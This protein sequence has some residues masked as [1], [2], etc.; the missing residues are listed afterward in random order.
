[1]W[2]FVCNGKTC[3]DGINNSVFI[4]IDYQMPRKPSARTPPTTVWLVDGWNSSKKTIC[5]RPESITYSIIYQRKLIGKWETFAIKICAGDFK[6][7]FLHWAVCECRPSLGLPFW[8]SLTLNSWISSASINNVFLF[9]FRHSV[10]IINWTQFSSAKCRLQKKKQ[11]KQKI[12]LEKET[13]SNQLPI[14]QME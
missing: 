10:C 13:V 5:R 1:M 6:C 4:S 9:N 8:L 3:V 14:H 7:F 11:K 2:F 12:R